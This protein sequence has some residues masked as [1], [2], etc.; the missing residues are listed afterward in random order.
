MNL[1]IFTGF[2]GVVLVTIGVVLAIGWIFLPF[3]I[4]SELRGIR[5]ALAA[6]EDLHR[7]AANKILM[8]LS[9]R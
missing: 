7:E 1:D 2:V 8:A 9:R 4:I 6:S 3:L 5:K